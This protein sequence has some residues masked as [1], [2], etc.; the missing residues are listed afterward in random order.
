MWV[1]LERFLRDVCHVVDNA[2]DMKSYT[3]VL[4]ELIAQ[5]L[6][7]DA[8]PRL[9]QSVN[10]LDV[11]IRTCTKITTLPDRPETWIDSSPFDRK[12]IRLCD[13]P[14]S[15]PSPIGLS[16]YFP[17]LCHAPFDGPS[18]LGRLCTVGASPNHPPVKVLLT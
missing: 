6:N 14:P 3:V 16:S 12:V 4:C 18:L 8:H 2:F 17:P 13:V 7:T 5:E 11:R 1:A 10:R 15:P 9:P